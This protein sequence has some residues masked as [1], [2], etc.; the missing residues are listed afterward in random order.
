MRLHYYT[1]YVIYDIIISIQFHSIPT[2]GGELLAQKGKAVHTETDEPCPACK[3]SKRC[4]NCGGIEPYCFMCRS[5]KG[6]C[7]VCHGTGHRLEHWK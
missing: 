1:D 5:V 6:E 2:R 7:L 3:G 4:K